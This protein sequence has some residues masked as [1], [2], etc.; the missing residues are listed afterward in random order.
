MDPRLGFALLVGGT[1]VEYIFPPLPG[2]T[3]VVA[4]A[5]L[6]A[7]LDW[8]V[9]PV[10]VAV[11][12]GSVAGS[13]LA[14][15]FGMYAEKRRR[16]R[17]DVPSGRVRRTVDILVRRFERHG[18]WYLVLNRFMP[19]VRAFFFV[20]A[21]LA[22]LRLPVVV[23]WSSLSAALWNSALIGLGLL[24]GENIATLERLVLRYNV[25][26]GTLVALVVGAAVWRAWRAARNNAH[27]R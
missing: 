17:G 7:A 23:L 2:D 21:G 20:A 4:G 1:L 14:W 12:L 13:T 15:S 27:S 8:P 24:V 16:A 26:A 25:A 11:T 9:W 5:A 6:V 10:F 18:A 19:G 22:G 3:V